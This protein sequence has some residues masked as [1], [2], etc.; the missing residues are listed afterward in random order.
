MSDKWFDVEWFDSERGAD[1]SM[2]ELLIKVELKAPKTKD[3]TLYTFQGYHLWFPR[4]T[5]FS[6]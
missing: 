1:E 2:H 5:S 3:S 4:Q 6:H